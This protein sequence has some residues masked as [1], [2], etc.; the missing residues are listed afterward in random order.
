[1]LDED[2]LD[3]E[4]DHERRLRDENADAEDA[5]VRSQVAASACEMPPTLRALR[6]RRGSIVLELGCGTGRYTTALAGRCAALLAVDFSWE[7]L[8]RLAGK[9]PPTG[10]VGLVQADAAR[11]GLAPGRFDR[12]L[13]ILISN[14]PSGD[15]RRAVYRAV[16][17]ALSDR[18]R[19]VRSTHHFRPDDRRAERS[20]RYGEG[21]IYRYLFERGE[22]EDEL[23]PYFGSVSV[24][25]IQVVS[26][27]MQ[28]LGLPV[29]AFSRVA[30]RVP[31]LK[32]QG[33]L[34]LAI[35]RRPTRPP[36][37]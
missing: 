23:R 37:D 15:L 10:V 34:L 9:L 28:R 26:H 24:R 32:Q 6:A 21:G 8:L 25:P 3:P 17:A 13:A 33:K 27:R 31:W 14:L 18:G 16:G 4:C 1:M 35:A 7:S 2:A 19:F 5:F 29:A 20:G 22:L 30:E 11:L 12:C 36:A